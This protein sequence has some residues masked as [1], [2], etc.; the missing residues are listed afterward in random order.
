MEGVALPTIVIVILVIA[1]IALSFA[2]AYSYLKDKTL[3]S[4]RSDVYQLFL[5]AEH[6][7]KESGAGKQKMKWVISRA[8]SL[9]PPWMQ[10]LITEDT[11]EKI[12][13]KWFQEVKD[14]L[15]DGKVNGS[16]KVLGPGDIGSSTDDDLK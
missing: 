3:D 9:L 8:R 16:Q 13:E 12:L 14:L 15:D 1:F 4:I 5:K 2:I 7:Y 11:L 6:M 10:A